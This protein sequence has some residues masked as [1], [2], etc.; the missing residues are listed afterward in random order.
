MA[1]FN[2]SAHAWNPVHSV[3]WN[4][5]TVLEQHNLHPKLELEAFHI[6]KQP[7]PLTAPPPPTTTPY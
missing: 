6:Q 4:W 7:P 1:D 2:V 5:V 3:D